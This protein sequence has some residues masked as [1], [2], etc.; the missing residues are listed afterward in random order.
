MKPSSAQKAAFTEYHVPAPVPDSI[1][2]STKYFPFD[3]ILRTLGSALEREGFSEFDLQVS[4]DGYAVYGSSSLGQSA[5]PSLF[6]RI[7]GLD[8][9]GKHGAKPAIREV[10]Y[11]IADLLT[12]ETEA[13]EQRKQSSQMPDPYSL[14][15]ILRGVGCFMDKRE[16]SQLARVGV[17]NRWV[18]IEYITS[19]GRL[20]KAHQ[21][22]DYFYDYWV[23]MYT[24]RGNRPKLPSLSD[25]TLFVTWETSLRQ[26]KVSRRLA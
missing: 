5:S 13:R 3:R 20:E 1:S 25:P 14:S 26:H 9:A 2:E 15:Q 10:H 18:T 24:Q 4:D 19:N 16:G 21:D 23:K 7:L 8:S 11:S 17:K 12:F 6:R 22:F